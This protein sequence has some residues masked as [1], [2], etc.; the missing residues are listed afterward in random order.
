M[1]T[2]SF[3]TVDRSGVVRERLFGVPDEDWLIKRVEALAAF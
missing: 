2:P 1:G 3:V